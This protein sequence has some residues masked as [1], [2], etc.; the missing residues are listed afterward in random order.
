MWFPLV[1]RINIDVCTE[2][3]MRYYQKHL[4]YNHKSQWRRGFHLIKNVQ[5]GK[6]VW[7]IVIFENS[8]IGFLTT[9]SVHSTRFKKKILCTIR[10]CVTAPSLT[11]WHDYFS[12]LLANKILY[13]TLFT[14]NAEHRGFVF[15]ISLIDRMHPSMCLHN[16]S[17]LYFFLCGLW[18][19]CPQGLNF[20][21]IFMLMVLYYVKMPHSDDCL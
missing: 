11:W 17:L 18:K 12:I 1:Y 16:D 19:G 8:Y 6:F 15:Y 21:Y 7:K 3:F 10:T 20:Y 9:G 5:F 2:W 4:R 14:I 13:V